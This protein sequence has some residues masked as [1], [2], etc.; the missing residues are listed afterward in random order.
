MITVSLTAAVAA[1]ARPIN[2]RVIQPPYAATPTGIPSSFEWMLSQLQQ[3]TTDLDL[4]VLPEFSDVP[5]RTKTRQEYLDAVDANNSRLL[6][7]CAETAARCSSVLF[8][9]AI[10]HTPEGIR[11]TTFAFDR[12]GKL[13][14]KYYKRHV[15]A[16]ERDDLGFDV[17]YAREWS[18]P[19]ILE[20]DG[21]KYA[22]LTCYDFYF[23]E[24]IGP[25]A[26]KEPDI[27]IG[28]SLQRSDKHHALEFINQ[29]C[30]YN[31]GAYLVR[32]SVSM[33]EDSTVGG[34]SMVVAPTGI[35]LG[36]MRSRTG[37]MDITFDPSE[38]YLKPAG[39]GNPLATHPSYMEI[40]RR[41]WLYRPGGSA[42][43]LPVAEAQAQ[44]VCALGGMHSLARR[45][46]LAAIGAAVGQDVPEVAVKVRVGTDGSLQCSGCSLQQVLH[47]FSCHCIFNLMLEGGDWEEASVAEL[48]HLLKAYDAL[49]HSY[50]TSNS[51]ETLRKVHDVLPKLPRCLEGSVVDATAENC[52]MVL[53]AKHNRVALKDARKAGLRCVTTSGRWGSKRLFKAGFDT[54]IISN[55][56]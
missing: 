21:L 22:F 39:F 31:T 14:G 20:I 9:N 4:I 40:G 44:R 41:P 19:D 32:A 10:D 6:K 42:I 7:A 45:S 52:E 53:V 36:N 27:V 11:N 15:T 51:I 48:V 8:V 38:K 56:R 34:S 50:V 30:A 35:I 16:G 12:T 3:C 46:P 29:F 28:C 33:G 24:M 1:Q 25:I 26:L 2:S 17:S 43:C 55:Y 18:E 13:V 47:K 23:Y 5:G 37:A 54:V 49:K